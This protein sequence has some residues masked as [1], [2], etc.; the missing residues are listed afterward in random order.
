MLDSQ[1]S[2]VFDPDSG[3]VPD[4]QDQMG[5]WILSG[6]CADRAVAELDLYFIR[7]NPVVNLIVHEFQRRV[8]EFAVEG[9]CAFGAVTGDVEGAFVLALVEAFGSDGLTAVT[10]GADFGSA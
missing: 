6:E 9:A 4:L 8:I 5:L 10:K 3:L 2:L 7:I 1:R